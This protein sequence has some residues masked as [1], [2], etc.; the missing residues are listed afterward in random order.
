MLLSEF[1]PLCLARLQETVSPRQFETALAPLTVGE[2]QDTWVVFVRN[3]F[4]FRL[5]KE[6][7]FPDILTLQKELCPSSPMLRLKV[8]EGVHFPPAR[9][10]PRPSAPETGSPVPSAFRQ[11][12]SA[13]EP[14]PPTEPTG[15]SR[16]KSIM[17]KRLNKARLD[18]VAAE[19]APAQKPA[20]RAGAHEKGTAKAAAAGSFQAALEPSAAASAPKSSSE[21]SHEH[22]HLDP[23]HTFETL[24]QGKGNQ[25]ALAA[26]LSIAE[27]P[28]NSLYNPFFIYGGSG[29]G[30]THLVQA[31]GNRIFQLNPKARVRYIHAPDYVSEVMTA[32]RTQSFERFK[33]QYLDLDLLIVD[34]V[35]FLSNKGRTMEEF[36]LLFNHFFNTKKQVVITCDRLP[37]KIENMDERLITRFQWGLTVEMEPPELEMRVAILQKKAALSGIQMKEDAAFFIADR[38]RSNVRE[39]EGAFKKVAARSLFEQKPIDIELI[40]E[41]LADIL[42]ASV[43]P[44]TL[45][46]IQST[47]SQFY[48]IKMA[49]L[50]GKKRQQNIVHPRQMAMLL[51]KDLTSLSL[52]A[53][54]EGFGGRDH[55]TVINAC[56][57]I[58]ALKKE[59]EDVR[60]EY[61]TLSVMLK[62]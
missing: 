10:A 41:A 34:D 54:G 28:G 6:R 52:A 42:A 61:E 53:I 5:V 32:A 62:G 51:A 46:E 17:A 40:H 49:D 48:R 4:L 55:T 24:V 3:E 18:E 37:T 22:T 21:S 11:P 60:R 36:F 23:E 26:A 31:I 35:Q 7:F 9:H 56:K 45:E 20:A 50:L 44:I 8:G 58:T 15:G 16:A 27:N 43:K 12:E 29:M 47:V 25:M 13:A 30:K 59:R 19:S 33:R 38:I 57:K 39:L 2:E 1:W 14:S